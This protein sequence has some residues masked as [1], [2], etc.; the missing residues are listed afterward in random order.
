MV[1][2]KAPLFFDYF[3]CSTLDIFFQE[4][5]HWEGHPFTNHFCF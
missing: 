1:W 4:V 5:C 3:L 2:F